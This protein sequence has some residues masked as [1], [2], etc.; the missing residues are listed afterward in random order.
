M[1]RYYVEFHG[2]EPIDE[3]GTE[4]EADNP[5]D[6]IPKAREQVRQEILRARWPGISDVTL[7]EFA[8]RWKCDAILINP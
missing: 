3:V 6:A 5:D 7:D 4:V 8:R 1:S 2:P